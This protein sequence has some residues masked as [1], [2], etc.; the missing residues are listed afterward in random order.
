MFSLGWDVGVRHG[1][2]VGGCGRV[3]RSVGCY[4]MTLLCGLIYH[5]SGNDGPT[6][7]EVIHFAEFISY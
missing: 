4:F 1:S 2:G 5:I 3:R 6:L 7:F